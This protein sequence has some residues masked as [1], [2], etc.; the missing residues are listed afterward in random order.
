MIWLVSY[1][2]GTFLG[3]RTYFA[4][5]RQE[6]SDGATELQGLGPL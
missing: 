2:F 6:K 3:S 5:E 1:F 4:Y